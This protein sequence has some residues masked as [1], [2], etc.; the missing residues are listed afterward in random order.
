MERRIQGRQGRDLEQERRSDKISY[1]VGARFEGKPGTN[2]E[3]LIG[4]AHA[5]CFTMA[6][7]LMLSEEG[8]T[9]EHMGHAVRTSSWRRTARAS[10]SR[11]CT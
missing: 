7:A 1:G 5:G 6:L 3:E 4:A 8:I 11:R 10:P 2:P 9:A